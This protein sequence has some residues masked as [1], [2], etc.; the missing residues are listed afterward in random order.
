M[1]MH[2]TLLSGARAPGY[3]KRTDRW[4]T[5]AINERKPRR[6]SEVAIITVQSGAMEVY[7]AMYGTNPFNR[8]Q[9][10]DM[11]EG[12]DA[13][14][15]W[16][17]LPVEASPDDRTEP[18]SRDVDRAGRLL[19]RHPADSEA[20][21]CTTSSILASPLIAAVQN[22]AAVVDASLA[23]MAAGAGNAPLEVLSRRRMP[24]KMWFHARRTGGNG[25][26]WL[27]KK[28]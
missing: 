5:D 19:R 20:F 7:S 21:T 23:R 22:G 24:K 2:Q 15:A 16:G 4:L 17:Y 6:F 3:R 26:W 14:M 10:S 13:A 27:D 8:V 11:L 9:A 12:F 25:R 28:T 18:R 1:S